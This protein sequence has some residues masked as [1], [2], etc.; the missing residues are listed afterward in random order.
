MKDKIREEKQLLGCVADD[1]TGASDAASFLQK[2]GMSTLL[3][4]EVQ[5]DMEI[6]RDT[7]A[8]VIALKSRTQETKAAVRDTLSA[9]RWLEEQGATKF[10]FKYC[11]TF[12]STREGN[13]G[14][15][16]DAVLE[17]LGQSYTVLCPSLPVNGRIVKEGK[18]YVKGVPLDE[19]PMRNHPLTP[20]WD[21]RIKELIEAQ[22]AFRA[23]ELPQKSLEISRK[24]LGEWLE[25]PALAGKHFYVIPDYVTEQDGENIVR[26]FG[27]LRFLTG[28]SGLLEP[29]GAVMKG[30]AGEKRSTALSGR[31]KN[32]SPGVV[33]AGSCSVATLAQIRDYQEQGGVSVRI[34]PAALLKGSQRVEDILDFV[35][36]RPD[37]EVLIY[38]SDEA[39]RV[40]E[41]QRLGRAEIAELIEGTLSHVAA[42]LVRK[43]YRRIVVAGGETSGAVTKALGFSAFEIGAS[44]APGVPMMTPLENRDVRL[45]LKSGN[46][47]Q[48]DFFTRALCMTKGEEI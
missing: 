46:F 41:V 14:P 47:G 16:A 28:G 27:E 44:V 10:Y 8:I 23:V 3:I 17:Y 36:Q 35:L 2:A 34:D 5:K 1:F 29:L 19:S 32:T 25:Q 45:V 15:V 4:N 26:L 31:T 48:Q 22:S 7:Q 20:M 11:S 39:E 37:Q 40:R 6:P 30:E 24:E 13:I 9:I 21:S 18:L 42:E 12:D 38:S 43:G 33:L